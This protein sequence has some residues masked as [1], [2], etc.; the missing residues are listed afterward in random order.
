MNGGMQIV[1]AVIIFTVYTCF[2]RFIQAVLI[3]DLTTSTSIDN[4]Q[5][6]TDAWRKVSMLIW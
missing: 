6:K 4:H 3:N 2:D 1:D 5:M